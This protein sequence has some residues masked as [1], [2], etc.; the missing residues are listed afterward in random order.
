MPICTI[1]EL[2]NKLRLNKHTSSRA[3]ATMSDD[4]QKW[5]MLSPKEKAEKPDYEVGSKENAKKPEGN[6]KVSLKV[7]AENRERE[8]NISSRTR[9]RMRSRT[10]AEEPDGENAVNF[11]QINNCNSMQLDY[12]KKV[13]LLFGKVTV[14]VAGKPRTGKSTALN[15]L[16]GLSL[17]ADCRVG[18]VTKVVVDSTILRHGV[19]VC[20]IDT[21]G[22]RAFDIGNKKILK[23]MREKIGQGADNFTLLY[24][25]SAFNRFEG[26]DDIV[27]MKS[28][29][30][31]FGADIWKRCIL[32]LTFCDTERSENYKTEDQD[33]AYR[34]HL[35][36]YAKAFKEA[37]EKCTTDVPPVKL[38]FDH[39]QGEIMRDTIVAVPV[40]RTREYGRKPNI[41]P[42]LDI[43]DNMHWPEYAFLEIVRKS[44]KISVSEMRDKYH[45]FAVA[46]A[47]GGGA[48]IG[49][50]IGGAIG[51]VGGPPG[52]AVGAG[53]G[54]TAG[55]IA[56][57]VLSFWS[58]K[59]KDS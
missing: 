52:A 33:E 38:V 17:P 58:R 10:R 42:G 24:C 19:Q 48:A 28:L 43:G 3:I 49:A 9:S 35:R 20:G 59:R 41:L 53:I 31:R 32:V 22:L 23:D 39:Q 2:H 50:I 57:S 18:S 8:H 21:P 4:D 25:I 15:N 27:I 12:I 14:M 40:A 7:K 16:L 34:E 11:H 54:A 51:L 30:D 26:K 46:A 13:L 36:A 29:S 5:E 37:L 45:L 1:S 56:G 55:A 47:S 44:G 6:R